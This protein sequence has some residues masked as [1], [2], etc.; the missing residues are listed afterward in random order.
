MIYSSLPDLNE[1]KCNNN[2]KALSLSLDA[3][4]LNIKNFVCNF[5]SLLDTYRDDWDGKVL[6][7]GYL[8]FLN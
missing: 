5:D 4:S 8:F 7:Y 2:T 1:S 6:L 3:E